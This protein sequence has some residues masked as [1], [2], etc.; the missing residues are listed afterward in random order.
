[1]DK[2]L[3]IGF[4][5]N[6][7]NYPFTLAIAFDKLGFDV[8]FVLDSQEKLHRPEYKFEA[9]AFEKIKIL[10][11]SPYDIEFLAKPDKIKYELLLDFFKDRDFLILNSHFISLYKEFNKKHV[12]ILTGSDIDFLASEKYVDEFKEKIF[13]KLKN[14]S[15]S[16]LK[17]SLANLLSGKSASKYP[18]ERLLYS[19]NK[20]QQLAGTIQAVK[21]VRYQKECQANGIKNSPFITYFP[22]GLI[23]FSDSVLKEIGAED[24]PRV[25]NLMTDISE[26]KYNKP[27]S[28]PHEV[29]I[30]NVA[31][32]NWHKETAPDYFS[33]LDFKGN[34]I[35]L[36]GIAKYAK[37]YPHHN[38]NVILVKK[39]VN[40]K[41]TFALVKNLGIEH[42][43]EWK[44]ELSQKQV[45]EEFEKADIVFD[46]L[47]TSL[48][49]MGGLD[50]LA[51]GRPLIANYRPEYMDS[52]IGSW[53]VCQAQN[54]DEVY[55]WLKELVPSATK[56]EE[57]GLKSR[58]FVSSKLSST[59]FASRIIEALKKYEPELCAE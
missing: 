49:G 18:N 55:G 58:E 30:F 37:D 54:V 1:M 43:I 41:E 36:K 21:F 35:M 7:N 29:R 38:L 12:V 28:K 40:L 11:F 59:A 39:G 22:K 52:F 23:K 17:I 8:K 26:I 33:E 5:G 20:I 16:S 45:I 6:T 19:Q 31:R 15:F 48:V 13:S 47:S 51:V 25:F 27:K 34:D 4:A 50:A 44:E 24:K 42:L 3:K 10:D 46:Q 56:R 57:T 9:S 2:R 32:F 53:P 14:E